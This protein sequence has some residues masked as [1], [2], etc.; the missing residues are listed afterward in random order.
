LE[1]I[2]HPKVAALQSEI[3]KKWQEEPLTEEKIIVVIEVP[4]LFEANLEK[5]YDLTLTVTCG[6][7]QWQRLVSRKGM[8]SKTKQSAI[9]QQLT[10]AEK[11][12]RADLTIDNSG[13]LEQ[14]VTQI[15]RLWERLTA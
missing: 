13:T 6:A 1:G 5:Q 3:L 10:E 8:S 9:N 14:T 7:R 15:E 4:L 2:I 11:I 12:R